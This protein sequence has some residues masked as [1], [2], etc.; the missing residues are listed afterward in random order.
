M[1]ASQGL[2]HFPT[3]Q[4]VFG[5]I[6]AC[7]PRN[8]QF[9]AFPEVSKKLMQLLQEVIQNPSVEFSKLSPHTLFCHLISFVHVQGV[10]PAEDAFHED[11]FLGRQ[12]SAGLR[13]C[14]VWEFGDKTLQFCVFVCSS[15]N[16]TSWTAAWAWKCGSRN[17]W[18]SGSWEGASSCPHS[19][20]HQIPGWQFLSTSKCECCRIYPF[21]SFRTAPGMRAGPGH[22]TAF[23]VLLLT[24]SLL[25]RQWDTE[26]PNAPTTQQSNPTGSSPGVLE[27]WMNFIT[28]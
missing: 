17:H 21:F 22:P 7:F 3:W 19:H 23:A 28:K 1:C 2:V 8:V 25:W 13:C 27:L 10:H 16:R 26:D 24:K 20:C 4:W 9:L 14:H 12:P 6:P 15:V 5:I 18:G 11:P